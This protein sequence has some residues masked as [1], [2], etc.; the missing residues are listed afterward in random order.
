[1][2]SRMKN[3]SATC[4]CLPKVEVLEGRVVAEA[5]GDAVVTD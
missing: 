4:D 5:G 2:S 3:L 1:M